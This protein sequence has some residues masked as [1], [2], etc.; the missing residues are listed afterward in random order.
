VEF[1]AVPEIAS[2]VRGHL[3]RALRLDPIRLAEAQLLVT[4][5]VANV[6]AHSNAGTFTL[7]VVEDVTGWIVEVTHSSRSDLTE[8]EHGLGFALLDRIARRWGHRFA[9]GRLTVWFEVRAAGT[10]AAIVDLDDTETLLRAKDDPAMREEAMRR[11]APLSASLARRFRGKGVAD[12]DLEQVAMLGLMNA[13]SRFEPE[14]GAF[15]AFA[16]ATITGEL[17]RYLRDRAWSV[18]LPRSLQE[19][20]LR[21]GRASEQLAQGLGRNA[22]PR[23]IAEYL[24]VDEEAVLEAIAANSAYHWESLVE[25]DAETGLVPADAIVGEPDLAHAA[26]T[27]IELKRSLD[28]L[29]DRER[30]II[31]LRFYEDLTQTEIAS[32]L[33]ISQMHVSRLLARAL[34][35]LRTV[36]D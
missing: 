1:P 33:G 16:A 13:V 18:R 26:D 4:E 34:G 31:R 7:N 32:K 21:T 12:E 14:R 24:E 27:S 3:A 25:P 8:A 35:R 23:E 28:L 20:T 22:T 5:V 30:E 11:F 36:L 29:P 9:E 17:K 19:L 6:V 2:E 10:G 15:E